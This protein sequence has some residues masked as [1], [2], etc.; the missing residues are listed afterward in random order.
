MIMTNN[1]GYAMV[2][3]LVVIIVLFLLSASLS[4]LINGKISLTASNFDRIQAKYN[5]EAGIEDGI[6]Q[7][8]STPNNTEYAPDN[9]KEF[10]NNPDQSWYEDGYKGDYEY[11][12]YKPKTTY[13]NENYYK[14]KSF[15]YYPK[16]ENEKIITAYL[17]SALDAPF[18]FGNEDY[19]KPDFFDRVQ[20]D[21]LNGF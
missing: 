3:V 6:T 5:A 17:N 13:N 18:I 15:G 2:I 1:K 10:P 21:N 9:E 16:K 11:Y 4:V 14:I 7:I 19:I 12:I 20:A 8:K